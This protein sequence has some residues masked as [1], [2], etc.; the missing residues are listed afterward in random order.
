MPGAGARLIEV[1]LERE[2]GRLIYELEYLSGGEVYKLRIDAVS[3]AALAQ[4]RD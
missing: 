3:G 1:E 2:H 4:E